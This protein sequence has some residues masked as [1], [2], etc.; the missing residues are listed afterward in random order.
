MYVLWTASAE[1]NK[2]CKNKNS[3]GDPVISERFEVIFLDVSH[4]EFDCQNGYYKGGYHADDQ[5][6]CFVSG[7]VKSE[8]HQF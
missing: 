8:F 6:R 7:K 4:Q 3:K 5:D 2:V 1:E